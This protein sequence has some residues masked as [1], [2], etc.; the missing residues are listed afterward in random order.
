MMRG[1]HYLDCGAAEG[2]S[3]QTQP[4]EAQEEGSDEEIE[5]HAF[6]FVG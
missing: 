1:A 4:G 5:V 6:K 3:T 2:E